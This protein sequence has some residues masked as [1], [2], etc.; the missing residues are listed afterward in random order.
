[1]H[2]HKV[3]A[4]ITADHGQ[5]PIKNENFFV[6][7]N[8]DDMMKL[9]KA[10]P[11]GD[12]RFVCFHVKE[13]CKEK[14]EKLFNDRYGKYARLIS[15][16]ELNKL[17]ILGPEEMTEKAKSRYGDYC[18]IFNNGYA[19]SYQ[20]SEINRNKLKKGCHSGDTDAEMKIPLIII[21]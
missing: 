6:I 2:S 10:P 9:L 4:V 18:A 14:F 15:Q 19:F 8:E 20:N 13:N 17:H 16:E 3:N 21:N 1:M 12:S 5:I 7:N 11:S